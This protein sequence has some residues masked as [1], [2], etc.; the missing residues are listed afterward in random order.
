MIQTIVENVAVSSSKIP[1]DDARCNGSYMLKVCFDDTELSYVN[2]CNILVDVALEQHL[3]PHATTHIVSD[4]SKF[5]C[6]FVTLI[7]T[8]II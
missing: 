6:D 7:R 2:V 1:H 8:R 3:P 5:I 4:Q